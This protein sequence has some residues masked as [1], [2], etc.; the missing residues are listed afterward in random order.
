MGSI[1]TKATQGFVFPGK[2]NPSV[3][4]SVQPIESLPTDD[5]NYSIPYSHIRHKKPR[6]LI[7]YSHGNASDLYS[8][9]NYLKELSQELS[10]D[11]V[12]W[13]YASYG[14][15]KQLDD[16]KPTE[17]NVYADSLKIF[18]YV[19]IESVKQ[20]IPII[21]YGRSLGS[22]PAIYV[23][24]NHQQ[25]IAGL[26]VES[27]FRSIARVVSTT[28]HN[29]YDLFDNE[30]CIQK[31]H[32]IPTL[33]IHGK[34]DHVVPFSHGEKLYNICP[35]EK[36][37]HFWIPNGHHNDIDSTYKS[38]LYIRLRGFIEHTHQES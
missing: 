11:V 13:D 8:V 18:D 28:L 2:D 38:E 14:L 29:I 9:N 21:V 7:F 33:F 12:G 23:A 22:A 27:G 35:C 20:N 16:V 1:A 25:D 17:E 36:K 34:Q 19:Q 26:I 24:A 3:Y 30:K 31:Q 32:L 15:H 6:A 37:E 5:E 4:S 10:V